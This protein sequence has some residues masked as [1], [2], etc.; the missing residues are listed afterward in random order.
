V[1]NFGLLSK[2]PAR[3]AGIRFPDPVDRQEEQTERDAVASDSASENRHATVHDR[4]NAVSYAED[5][6]CIHGEDAARLSHGS[7]LRFSVSEDFRVARDEVTAVQRR[8][9]DTV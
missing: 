7:L 6:A 3:L 2:A 5:R 4:L 1:R 9:N 8:V